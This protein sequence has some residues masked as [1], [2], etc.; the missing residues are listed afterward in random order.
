[1]TSRPASRG[2][3]GPIDPKSQEVGSEPNSARSCTAAG[4]T[5][6][7]V[8]HRPCPGQGWSPRAEGAAPGHCGPSG[9]L[10]ASDPV[11]SHLRVHC[12]TAGND[13]QGVGG[14]LASR[15]ASC[16]AQHGPARPAI[17]VQSKGPRLTPW[18]GVAGQCDTA[19]DGP[20]APAQL[21]DARHRGMGGGRPWHPTRQQ[22]D[23]K[24][25]GD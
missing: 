21:A 7:P 2:T 22:G 6:P 17:C 4:P 24:A 5:G 12:P 18:R 11:G 23:A 16:S 19:C 25:P 8:R 1:M 9:G 10:R 3:I 15:L 13:G 20:A 14:P